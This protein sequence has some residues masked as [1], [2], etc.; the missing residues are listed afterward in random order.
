MAINLDSE[1][2]QPIRKT[3]PI[4]VSEKLFER[5]RDASIRLA[6]KNKGKLHKFARERLE[7]L[8]DEVEAALN[9]VG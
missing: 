8:L 1:T 6:K 4:P 5:Y 2:P 7:Q 9:K 3:L